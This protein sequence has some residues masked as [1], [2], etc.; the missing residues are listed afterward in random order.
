L[1]SLQVELADGSALPAE[2]GFDTFV[3]TG[4]AV[5]ALP[6]PAGNADAPMLSARTAAV[7]NT[8]G[9]MIVTKCL[10]EFVEKK[11]K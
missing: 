6:A 10:E 5:V 11:G 9:I 8:F 7:D 4:E 1:G 3:V 2:E